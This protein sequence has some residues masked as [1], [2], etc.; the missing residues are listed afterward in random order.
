[1]F[2]GIAGLLAVWR[3][4]L[5]V[6]GWT[7]LSVGALAAIA[8][9][10]YLNPALLRPAIRAAVVI[11]VAYAGVLYGDATG[12]ADVEAQWKDAR[13]AAIAAEQERDAAIAEGLER[14]YAPQ[15][16]A[17]KKQASTNKEQADGYEKKLLA[18]MARSAAGGNRAAGCELGDLADRLHQRR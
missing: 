8:L 5:H 13:E 18:L 10:V 16:E 11:A 12:R 6:S 17:L 9:V 15:L 7:G 3:T 4:V 2:E 1:M 14:K